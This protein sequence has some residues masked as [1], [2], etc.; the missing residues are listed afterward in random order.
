MQPE[1]QVVLFLYQTEV[2]NILLPAH[3]RCSSLDINS[4]KE[5]ME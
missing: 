2:L 3:Y 4:F 1:Y 5:L